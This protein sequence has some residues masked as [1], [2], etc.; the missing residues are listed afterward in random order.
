MIRYSPSSIRPS[1]QCRLAVEHDERAEDGGQ[2]HPDQQRRGE[3]ERHRH[4]RDEQAR[5]HQHGRQ[6][7][8]DLEAGVLDQADRE[9][10]PACA[11][12]AGSPTTFSTAL[13]A[14]ATTTSPTNAS[15]RPSV[16]IAGWRAWT[17]QSAMTAAPIA[18]AREHAQREPQRPGVLASASPIADAPWPPRSE[19]GIEA[20]KT[21]SSM[22]DTNTE[23]S[24]AWPLS[25][26][27]GAVETVGIA[28]AADREHEDDRDRPHRRARRTPGVPFLRPPAKNASPRTSRLLP[29]IEPISAVWV[30]TTRPSWRANN[31]MN[32]SGRLPSADCRTPV[33]PGPKW[34]AQVVGA[35]ADEAREPGEGRPPRRRRSA[36]V[37][38]PGDLED[39][40]DHDAR[41]RDAEH[42]EA[43][44]ARSGRRSRPAAGRTSSAIGPLSRARRRAVNCLAR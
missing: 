14:S 25:G 17:N 13:P 24:T 7:E 35:L 4:G 41:H 16:A 37:G 1:S 23:I 36:H 43:G 34:R 38:R 2:R 15:D 21:T 10:G 32:S 22:I 44:H 6:G 26:P 19:Y 11:S 30:R 5:Q 3:H 29:R 31:E 8:G 27:P 20:A 28:S 42:H 12:P 9:V 33:A 39:R 40:G 18:R